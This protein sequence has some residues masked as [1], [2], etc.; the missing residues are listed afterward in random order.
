MVSA[1]TDLGVI[2]R[3]I[4]AVASLYM[5]SPGPV[6]Q[7]LQRRHL[8]PYTE[9]GNLKF[10][11]TWTGFFPLNKVPVPPFTWALQRLH[12]TGNSLGVVCQDISMPGI[13]AQCIIA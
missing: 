7:S 5:S 1:V 13:N 12:L 11:P 9:G 3:D 6:S 4:D 10:L 2:V 8:E